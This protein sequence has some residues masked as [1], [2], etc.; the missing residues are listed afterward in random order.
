MNSEVVLKT[1][2]ILNLE[3]TSS[4]LIDVQILVLSI[5]QC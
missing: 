4:L 1:V 3:M 5:K 2:F